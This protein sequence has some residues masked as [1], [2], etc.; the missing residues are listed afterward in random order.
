MI[1]VAI[2]MFLLLIRVMD[3]VRNAANAICKQVGPRNDFCVVFFAANAICKPVLGPWN[4]CEQ[5]NGIIFSWG[6]GGRLVGD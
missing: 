2:V 4:E 5:I 3:Q 1:I 6:V